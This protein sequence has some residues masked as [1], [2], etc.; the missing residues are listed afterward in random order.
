MCFLTVKLRP[1]Q[2][3]VHE[4]KL[5]TETENSVNE[6]KYRKFSICYRTKKPLIKNKYGKQRNLTK[7]KEFAVNAVNKSITVANGNLINERK[8]TVNRTE[9]SVTSL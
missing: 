9:S 8:K 2:S 5:L 6:Q 1:G 7:L 4:R 3:S